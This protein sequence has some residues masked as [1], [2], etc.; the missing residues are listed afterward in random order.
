MPSTAHHSLSFPPSSVPPPDR[1]CTERY[2]PHIPAR[3]P[4]W[5]LEIQLPY[6][7]E[8]LTLVPF[9]ETLPSPSPICKAQLCLS[10]SI[11]YSSMCHCRHST[12]AFASSSAF[13][14]YGSQTWPKTS[15]CL[16]TPCIFFSLLRSPVHAS[17]FAFGFSG[18]QP[19]FRP[20]T[21]HSFSLSICLVMPTSF[22]G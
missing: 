9:F 8:I 20:F 16:P 22:I 11:A 2:T 19:L 12:P 18:L 1:A 15:L 10:L 17:S 21:S 4:A 3:T 14:V 7:M 5:T 6:F 13:G